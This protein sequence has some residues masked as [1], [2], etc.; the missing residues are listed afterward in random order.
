MNIDC[1]SHDHLSRRSLLQSAGALSM[2]ALANQL[3]R[4]SEQSSK[5]VR[6]KSVI[7]LWLKG[8]PSQYETFDPH[9]GTKYGG[10]VAAID[11]T[12]R[13]V[14]ISEFLPQTAEQMHRVAL[15]RSVT[16]KEGDHERAF[17]N[18]QTG[19]RPDPTVVHPSIGSIVCHELPGGADIPRHISILP[20]NSAGRGGYLGA[21]YDAFK[22]YDPANK[23]PDIRP[24]VGEKRFQRRVDGLM[25]VVESNF[26]K[27][28]L[29]DL[30]RDRTLHGIAT[31]S[32]LT[33][34]DSDQLAAFEVDKE[35]KAL[36]A[37][38]GETAFGRGCLAAARLIEVGVRCVEVGLSGWD[39]HADNHN[40]Q[41]T[42]CEILDP[43]YATLLQVLADRDLLD[44]TLVVCGGEFGRT[45]K[46]NPVGGRDHWPHGFSIALAGCGLRQGIVHGATSPDP[47]LDNK[48]ND[49]LTNVGDPVT[50]QDIHATILKAL[51][52]QFERELITPIGR[53]LKL[54]EGTPIES[55]LS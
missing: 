29:R 10:E 25:D 36:R 33:M 1:G 14:Q 37:Q 45:P 49:L 31:K 51:D 3:A 19:W 47:K 28:R 22:V 35:S 11:T 8:A 24:Y 7:I 27:G 15:V 13:D 26:R 34:M 44:S 17:Y 48:E 21:K 53:P 5:P 9:A 42:Q 41:R 52:V 12:A 20:D 39:T 32:A 43:A 2:T 18:I 38:F 50:V 6:P 46:I 30:D 16:S 4:G 54:S 23:V 40:G 55:I